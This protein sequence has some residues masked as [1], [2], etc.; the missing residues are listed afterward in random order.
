MTYPSLIKAEEWLLG[1]GESTE[2]K[3][4]GDS[5]QS[6]LSYNPEEKRSGFY[7]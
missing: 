1:A 5:S 4:M 6:A 2:V 7:L 3:G